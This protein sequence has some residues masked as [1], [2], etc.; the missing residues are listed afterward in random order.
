MSLVNR[1]AFSLV[2][3]GALGA[4]PPA[5]AFACVDLQRA[6]IISNATAFS[7]TPVVAPIA[8][9]AQ[10]MGDAFILSAGAKYKF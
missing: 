7:G 5:A 8:Y 3:I 1:L 6:R 2:S 9:N 4:A 10:A